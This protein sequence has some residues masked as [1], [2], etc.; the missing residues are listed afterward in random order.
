MPVLN[1][2]HRSWATYI[3]DRVSTTLPSHL[4]PSSPRLLRQPSSLT[5]RSLSPGVWKIAKSSTRFISTRWR[6]AGRNFLENAN[7]RVRGACLWE[8]MSRATCNREDETQK[9]LTNPRTRWYV[10][11]YVHEWCCCSGTATS[12][13]LACLDTHNTVFFNQDNYSISYR[14]YK[15]RAIEKALLETYGIISISYSS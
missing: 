15:Q 4:S 6:S 7:C 2:L 8:S 1:T 5:A 11:I 12:D 9:A 3:T 14:K 10:L 13:Y